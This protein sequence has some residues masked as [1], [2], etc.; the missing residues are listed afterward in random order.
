MIRFRI[1][2]TIIDQPSIIAN[3]EEFP[4]W[5]DSEDPNI[6]GTDELKFT[7]SPS[8]FRSLGGFFAI[9]EITFFGT[10]VST[11]DIGRF[12]AVGVYYNSN[13]YSRLSMPTNSNPSSLHLTGSKIGY[14]VRLCANASPEQLL[15]QNGT[16]IENAH[17]ALDSGIYDAV[18]IG[19]L[20]WLTR[21]YSCNYTSIGDYIEFGS[22]TE[23]EW[24]G[25]LA[26]LATTYT[27]PVGNITNQFQMRDI[28]GLLYN[29]EAIQL[30][31]GGTNG[32]RVPEKADFDDML[33][34]VGVGNA[35][36]IKL[37]YQVNSPYVYTPPSITRKNWFIDLP[38]N[39]N[40][41]FA[42]NNSLFAFENTKLSRSGEF[43]IPRTPNNDD[44]FGFGHD[45]VNDGDSVRRAMSAQLFYDGGI[46][47][48]VIYLSKYGGGEYSAVFVYGELQVLKN[49]LSMGKIGDYI[50]VTDSLPTA[51]ATINSGYNSEG[52]ISEQFGWYKYRNLV[53]NWLASGMN[54]SP[55]VRLYYLLEKAAERLGINLNMPYQII[56]AFGLILPTQTAS[57]SLISCNVQGATNSLLTLT[58]GGDFFESGTTE[59]KYKTDFFGIWKGKDCTIFTAKRDCVLKLTNTYFNYAIVT[60]KGRKFLTQQSMQGFF[61]FIEPQIVELKKG[62]YF[63][64]VNISDYSFETPVRDYSGIVNI[65]FEVYA[66]SD[67][68]V[69]LGEVYYLQNNLPEVTFVDL[70]KTVANLLRAG[71]NYDATTNTISLFDFNFN[72][73]NA[74]ELEN[75]V[76]AIKSVDRTFLNYAKKNT[77]DFKSEE[78]VKNKYSLDYFINNDNLTADKKLYTVPFSDGLQEQNSDIGVRDFEYSEG[79]K[80]IAKNASICVA[81][82]VVG[83]EFLKHVSQFYINF[84]MID[85]D[86]SKLKSIINDSTT[87]VVQVKMSAATF[88]KIGNTDCYKYRGRYFCC[89][90]GNHSGESAELTLVK[91]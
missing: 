24:Q 20:L 16:I 76:I 81:S 27:V 87:I 14:S 32:F 52:I 5:R 46:I 1:R 56:N 75:D 31:G 39:F 80:K 7:A 60:D 21:N 48:G 88:L 44:I 70:L 9:G 89:V 8:G 22:F 47:D 37:I 41:S 40:F 51:G 42:Y 19:S 49:A 85:T 34:Y 30:L 11:S 53:S 54:L 13:N 86:G 23:A 79:W 25:T 64:V 59:F 68:E 78:Y 66:G 72:K 50:T 45:F 26:P 73:A 91:I 57:E 36:K 83:E 28:F 43:S 3:R 2:P 65:D 74:I 82:K 12:H 67:T 84:A 18:K 58:G 6:Y 63:S 35:G 29:F 61:A 4:R 17:V 55:V 71:I 38:S 77:I 69:D 33:S 90:N 62:D 15:L 10:K